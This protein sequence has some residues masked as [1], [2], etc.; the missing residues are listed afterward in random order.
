M[1]SHLLRGF[2]RTAS[3]P[4]TDSA[5]W[6]LR[7]DPTQDRG[8]DSRRRIWQLGKSEDNLVWQWSASH[9]RSRF[10]EPRGQAGARRWR[11]KSCQ[12]YVFLKDRSPFL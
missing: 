5:R 11:R 8:A 12:P 9:T 2:E 6:V 3:A 4:T 10:T 7:W 1:K